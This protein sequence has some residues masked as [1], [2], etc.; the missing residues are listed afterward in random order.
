MNYNSGFVGIDTTGIDSIISRVE[1]YNLT[2]S[3]VNSK[4]DEL[5]NEAKVSY[6][7][8][9]IDKLFELENQVMQ[10]IEIINENIKNNIELLNKVKNIY[11][12]TAASILDE[13]KNV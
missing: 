2:D 10:K 3:S 5:F 8:N 9:N 7:S 12:Q 4:L 6:I 13:T 11:S 1:L